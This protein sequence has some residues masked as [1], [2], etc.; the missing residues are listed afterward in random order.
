MT[1]KSIKVNAAVSVVMLA[2]VLIMATALALLLL[3]V[4]MRHDPADFESY[5]TASAQKY[6]VNPNLIRAVIYTESRFNPYAV[7][8]AGELGLM[9]VLP[10][11]AV[12]DYARV[13]GIAVPGKKAL[14]EPGLNIDIGTWY[15]AAGLHAYRD[16]DDAVVLA[17][18][19]YNAGNSRARKWAPER[20]DGDAI[21]NIDIESTRNYVEKVMKRYEYYRREAAK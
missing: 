7:G 12:S 16:Y 18:C 11:G 21:A 19:R 5:I 3:A 20:P 8:A 10:S 13:H 6:R 1:G 4:F 17:L 15:L 9:Q 2:A 14:L